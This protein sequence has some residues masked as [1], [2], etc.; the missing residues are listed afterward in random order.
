MIITLYIEIFLHRNYKPLF[1]L[2][3]EGVLNSD[4]KQS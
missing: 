2:Y 4:L 3:N 1:L